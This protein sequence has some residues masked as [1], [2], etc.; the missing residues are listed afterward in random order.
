[1]MTRAA[2]ILP[3]IVVCIVLHPAQ[4]RRHGRRHFLDEPLLVSALHSVRCKRRVLAY[5]AYEALD[6]LMDTYKSLLDVVH[7]FQ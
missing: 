3:C 2:R 6:C 7:P 1:M 4:H 5:A